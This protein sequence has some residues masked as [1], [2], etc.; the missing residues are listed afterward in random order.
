[1]PPSAATTAATF[2]TATGKKYHG[3]D[4]GTARPRGS[5]RPCQRRCAAAGIRGSPIPASLA[6]VELGQRLLERGDETEV[7]ELVE[8][9]RDVLDPLIEIIKGDVCVL[10]L[11]VRETL[12]EDLVRQ[13]PNYG[14]VGIPMSG[15]SCETSLLSFK[16]VDSAKEKS[17]A[18]VSVLSTVVSVSSVFL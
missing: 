2:T 5:R 10:V 13:E 6:R 7:G 16:L 12:V 1:M 8:A 3:R 11:A 4:C 15:I 14:R 9:R 17:F 18:K